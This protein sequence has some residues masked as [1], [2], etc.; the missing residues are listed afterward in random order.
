MSYVYILES[1][2][3]G[4]YYI[5]S[6]ENVEARLKRHNSWQVFST[7]PYAPYRVAFKKEF[8]TTDEARR[9]ELKLK[10]LKR[11]DYIA[12]IVKNQRLEFGAISSPGRAIDS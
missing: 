2:I 8:D 3:N 12:K 9:V 4:K 7:K 6:T 10:R 5:G 1:L 11:K